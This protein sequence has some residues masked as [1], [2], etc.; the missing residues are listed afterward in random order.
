[1]IFYVQ[2]GLPLNS[3][4]ELYKRLSSRVDVKNREWSLSRTDFAL[5]GQ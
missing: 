4:G 3:L 1:M 2:R 5:F